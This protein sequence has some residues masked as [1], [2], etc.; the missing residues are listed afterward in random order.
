MMRETLRLAWLDRRAVLAL[1][2]ELAIPRG[3][4]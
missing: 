2:V 3:A 1:L 4:M